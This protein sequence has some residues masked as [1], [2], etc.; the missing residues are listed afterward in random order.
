MHVDMS[1]V[2]WESCLYNFHDHFLLEQWHYQR[3]DK[4]QRLRQYTMIVAEYERKFSELIPYAGISD[5][6]PLIVQHFIQGLNNRYIGGV[7]VFQPKT[8]EDVIRQ[9]IL[10]EQNITLGHGGFVGDPTS[11][12][13]ASGSKNAQ[14]QRSSNNRKPLFYGGNQGQQQ[15]GSHPLAHSGGGGSNS[16]RS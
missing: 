11:G 13:V 16:E 15:K 1:I 8:L 4:F 2:T 12:H 9:A 5:S 10:V 14:S 3:V 6:S 7:K